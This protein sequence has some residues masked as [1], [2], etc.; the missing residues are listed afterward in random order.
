MMVTVDRAREL[1]ADT[2]LSVG[3]RKDKERE[4]GEG[5]EGIDGDCD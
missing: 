1:P 2:I 5:G 3:Q 4:M